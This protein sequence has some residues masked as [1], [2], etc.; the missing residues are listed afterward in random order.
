MRLFQRFILI[1]CGFIFLTGCATQKNM[2]LADSFWQTQHQ[3]I[4]VVTTKAP[5]PKLY[6]MGSQS[7][8]DVAISSTMTNGLD[9]YISHANLT[10]YRK[11]PLDFA[12]QLK[13]RNVYAKA[14]TEAMNIDPKN[15]T[16]FGDSDK[17]LVIQLEAW[18]V[19][20]NYSGFIPIGAPKAYCVL[21][22]ELINTKN[23]DILWRYQTTIKQPV[24][25]E[26]DQPPNYPNIGNA[27][28]SAIQSAQ[29]DLF[30]S[31]FSGH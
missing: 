15:I 18:G 8:I 16:G 7:L 25:G 22:G 3:K 20:R 21:K 6:K 14:Y 5:E 24:Q 2:P 17:L 27:L 1:A 26:W 28:T 29:Q 19:V 4:A 31:F 11:L 9:N 30:D 10:W 13:Q 23:N 12:A